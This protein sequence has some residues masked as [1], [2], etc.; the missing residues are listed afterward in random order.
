M[1]NNDKHFL[2]GLRELQED[3]SVYRTEDLLVFFLFCCS[4]AAGAIGEFAI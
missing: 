3:K 4:C 1:K 2:D